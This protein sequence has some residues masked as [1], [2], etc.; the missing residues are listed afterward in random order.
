MSILK[1]AT[2]SLNVRWFTVVVATI[3]VASISQLYGYEKVVPYLFMTSLVIFLSVMVFEIVRIVLFYKEI[4]HELLNP[5]KTFNFFTIAVAVNLTG[6]CFSRVFHMHTTASIFWYVAISL[7]LGISLSS[8]SIL[9]LHRKLEDRKIEDVFHGGWFFTTVG[10]QSTAFLGLVVAEHAVRHVLFIQLFSFALWSIGASLYLIF[11]ALIF[12]RLIFYHFGNDAELSPYWINAGAATFTTLTGA[13]LYL[14][15]HTMSSPL[16]ETLPFLKGLSMFFWSAGLWWMP[17]LVV[18]AIR[19]QVYNEDGFA[20]TVGY[21]EIAF[22]IGLHAISTQQFS[23]LF[24]GQYLIIMSKCFSITCVIVWAFSFFFTIIHLV[25]SSIWVPVNDLTINFVVPY[26]F[27]LH[28]RLFRVKEIV[29][30][31]LDQTI[32]GVLKK[33]Y[34][35]TTSDNLTCWISYDMQAKKWYFDQVK[36]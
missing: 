10:T 6:V 15:I 35:I 21:W 16:I 23:R 5:G 29:N 32:Q 14:H 8:F 31:W 12:L 9:F 7:W 13:T 33:R 26:S 19:K 34:C 11:M 20:F 2:Y 24:E 30:E 28:G 4:L 18:M 3:M 27:K 17:F 22:V 25:R 1:I 36:D